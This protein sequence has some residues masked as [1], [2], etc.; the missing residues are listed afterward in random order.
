MAEKSYTVSDDRTGVQI[1]QAIRPASCRQEYAAEQKLV[2]QHI[3]EWQERIHSGE[4]EQAD[5]QQCLKNLRPYTGP[6]EPMV[7][8]LN[9]LVEKIV[10]HAPDK[11]SRHRKQKIETD[12]RAAVMIGFADDPCIAENS[13]DK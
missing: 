8:R 13:R 1:D 12:Y 6:E 3:W 9:D 5:L 4:Q 7:K 11:S 10:I 2:K